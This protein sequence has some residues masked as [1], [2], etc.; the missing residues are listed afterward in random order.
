LKIGIIVN[1]ESG[2][3]IRRIISDAFTF[4]NFE[5]LN[6]VKRIVNATLS[7]V[8][9]EFVFMPDSFGF[10]K[11][12]RN[13]IPNSTQILD[14]KP[15]NEEDTVRATRLMIEKNVCCIIVLGGDGTNRLVAK[16]SNSTPIVPISTGTNNAFPF[17]YDGT[18]VGSAIAAIVKDKKIL[19]EA[20]HREKR[21]EIIKNGK[22]YDIALVDVAVIE[23]DFIG[24]KA[25][26]TTDNIREI[27][28]SFGEVKNIGLS[29]VFGFY[30][31][32]KRNENAGG[33][34]K[35]GNGNLSLNAP[36]MPGKLSKIEIKDIRKIDLGKEIA[37]KHGNMILSL[38]GERTI[39]TGKDAFA[40]RITKNG[41]VVLDISKTIEIAVKNR[42]FLTKN[43]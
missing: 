13:E 23:N 20:T 26:F 1:P 28:I 31:P 14:F 35:I 9:A 6:I 40:V 41:P 4:N 7:L 37:I 34:C 11:Y 36:L 30:L 39:Y 5:K 27:F 16:A 3:D 19:E 2:K 25:I 42:M 32:V 43:N 8:E 24:S 22:L 10:G 21:L 17:F 33:F 12:I 38:D 29:S 15:E 18:I